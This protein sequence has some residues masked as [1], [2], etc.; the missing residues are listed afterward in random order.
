MILVFVLCH[1]MMVS[2]TTGMMDSRALTFSQEDQTLTANIDGDSLKEV[3]QV[4]ANQLPVTIT[5]M[6]FIRDTP[7]ST[8]FT[9]LPLEQG[10]ERLLQGQDYALLYSRASASQLKEIIVLPRQDASTN[11][12]SAET[13]AVISPTEN[14]QK[15]SETQKQHPFENL[16]REGFVSAQLE[17]KFEALV[18]VVDESPANDVALLLEASRDNDPEIREIA[19]ALLE[20][21]KP[22]SP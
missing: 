11:S 6:G 17:D 7:L 20:Q 22:S 14:H 10:I 19:A 5:M 13:M 16:D 3:L 21:W 15:L 8:I 4:L 2:T 18:Q 12:P 9:D 1:T